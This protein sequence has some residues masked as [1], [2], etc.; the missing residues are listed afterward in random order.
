MSAHHTWFGECRLQ[1]MAARLSC[2][3]LGD[4]LG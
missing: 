4:E 1:P 2:G 3:T